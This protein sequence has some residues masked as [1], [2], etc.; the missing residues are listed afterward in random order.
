MHLAVPVTQ[1]ISIHK[2]PHKVEQVCKQL[3]NSSNATFPFLFL[4]GLHTKNVCVH[5][6]VCGRR[7]L[8]F[9]WAG[10]VGGG[11]GGVDGWMHFF[12]SLYFLLACMCVIE[13]LISTFLQ[14]STRSVCACINIAYCE[15]QCINDKESEMCAAMC[16][17]CRWVT[18][19]KLRIAKRRRTGRKLVMTCVK[20]RL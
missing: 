10:K 2:K 15:M 12:V 14:R 7:R 9:F 5:L 20:Y 18:G 17:D 6:S 16:V 1:L 13:L 11:G 3:K 4:D 8:F 19:R